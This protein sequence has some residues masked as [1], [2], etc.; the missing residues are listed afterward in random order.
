MSEANDASSS[1][2]GARTRVVLVET[3]HPGNIG[4]AARAMKAMGLTDLRLVAPERFP[5]PEATA[6]AVGA[7]D[8]LERA[9][10]HGTLAEALVGASRVYGSSA[11]GRRVDWPTVTPREAARE[12]AALDEVEVALVFG[13]ERTGLSNED[14]DLCQRLVA[15]PTVADFSSLNLAQAVQVIAYEVF[16]AR[17]ARD[18]VAPR[19]GRRA[20]ERAARADEVAGLLEHSL[21]VMTTVGFHDPARPKLLERRLSRLCG[22]AGLIDSEVQILRGFLAALEARLPRE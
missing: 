5:D 1:Q 10:V 6:L 13:P 4:S 19:R 3:S 17:H 12:I 22:R 16:V 15:I 8:L 11:R 14:L 20:S 7:A 2:A 18:S 9:T 21:A